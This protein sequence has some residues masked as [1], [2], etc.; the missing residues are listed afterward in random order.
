MND[1][2]RLA[3]MVK[4]IYENTHKSQFCWLFNRFVT[5][6]MK[7]NQIFDTAT[8]FSEITQKINLR[9]NISFTNVN[10]SKI[11]EGLVTLA[12][13]F[14]IKKMKKSKRASNKCFKES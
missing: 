14:K 11:I 5:Y 4:K 9:L 3:K 13:N 7:F 12:K 2:Q 6:G 1:F 8:I 10:K